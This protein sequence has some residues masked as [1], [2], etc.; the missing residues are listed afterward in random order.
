MII[1]KPVAHMKTTTSADELR[2]R[3]ELLEDYA[4]RYR[5]MATMMDDAG[6]EEVRVTGVVTF[7]RVIDQLGS[8]TRRVQLQIQK[9]ID[10]QR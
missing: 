10:E 6:L 2:L 9:E 3:D 1:T 7:E 5:D 8:N 4:S